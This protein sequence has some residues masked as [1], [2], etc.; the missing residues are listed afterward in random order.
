MSSQQSSALKV[1]RALVEA[2]SKKDYDTARTLLAPD[3]HVIAT[4]TDPALPRTDL[5]GVDAYLEGL[6]YFADPI[7]AGSVREL[8]SAG[9]ERNAMLTLDLQT[10]LGPAGPVQAPC[11]RL[12]LVEDGL[13]KEEQVIF[14]LGQE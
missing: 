3:V 2:W 13:V 1:A 5:T 4:S 8:S 12:Y 14:Y 9:D 7:V 11:A 6:A 10:A